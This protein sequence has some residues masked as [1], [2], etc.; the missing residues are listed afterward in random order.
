MRSQVLSKSTL[1]CLMIVGS[2]GCGRWQR[3]KGNEKVSSQ[4]TSVLVLGDSLSTGIFTSPRFAL[5]YPGITS[6]AVKGER[7]NP[8]GIIS[9]GGVPPVRVRKPEEEISQLGKGVPLLAEALLKVLEWPE[10]SWANHLGGANAPAEGKVVLAAR[11]GAQAERTADEVT[12][13]VENTEDHQKPQLPAEIYVF[14]SGDDLCRAIGEQDKMTSASDYV[15]GI[16]NGVQTL[17]RDASA[18]PRGSTVYLVSHLDILQQVTNP[19]ILAS[20]HIHVF[21]PDDRELT[22]QDFVKKYQHSQGSS[23]PEDQAKL[24]TYNPMNICYNMLSHAAGLDPAAAQVPLA[25]LKATIDSYRSGLAS[26]ATELQTDPLLSAAGMKVKLITTTNELKMDPEDLAN[27]CFH[28]S[29]QGQI[30][31]AKTISAG[32]N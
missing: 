18:N 29:A 23:R 28:L 19:Q 16:R 7:A 31:L 24:F 30:K 4:G 21:D 6:Q 3:A 5:N 20:K 26:L 27:D 22:C 8:E 2:V 32:K 15:Q 25:T 1:S 10:L 14:F 11:N 17:A 9:T 12:S 13:W